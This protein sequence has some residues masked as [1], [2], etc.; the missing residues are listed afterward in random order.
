MGKIDVFNLL[1]CFYNREIVFEKQV[2]LGFAFLEKSKR[3]VEQFKIGRQLRAAFLM[4]PFKDESVFRDKNLLRRV[5]LAK[6]VQFLKEFLIQ[7]NFPG[8]REKFGWAV[9]YVSKGIF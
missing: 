2:Y 6:K 5:L 8:L 7:K 9:F 3:N 4:M 1:R